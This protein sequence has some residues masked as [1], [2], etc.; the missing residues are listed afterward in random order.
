ME[1]FIVRHG[2]TDANINGIV[3]GWMDTKLNDTG[4]Q[5][6]RAAAELFTESIDVIYS[7]DLTRATQTAHE[8]V[9]KYANVPYIEDDRLRERHFGDAT[10][11]HRDRHD[12]EV[13]WASYDTISIPNAESLK[14]YNKRVQSFI[15]MIKQS[16][17]KKALIVTH[18]GTINRIQDLTSSNHVH[19]NYSNAAI[20]HILLN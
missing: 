11:D 6:A 19:V 13:F 1:L 2:Q 18:G 17:Y 7:S 15:D 9:K 10:G 5:Q 20:V 4:L 3:Q 16:G 14:D 12:W 8:F